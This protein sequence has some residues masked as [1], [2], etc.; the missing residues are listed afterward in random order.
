MNIY[1]AIDLKN[2]QV[3]RLRKG[4]H[5]EQTVYSDSP[6]KVAAGLIEDGARWLHVV[7]LDAA[8]NGEPA[9]M[10]SLMNILAVAKSSGAK[11]QNGGGIRSK[12]RIKTLLD[13]GIER[14][15]IGSA[16]LKDRKWFESILEEQT[17]PNHR[18]ALGLDTREGR[19]ATRGWTEQLDVLATEI[20]GGFRDSGL[21]AIIYTDISRDGMLSGINAEET[22]S[23]IDSTDI[24]VI[25]SGGVS[26]IDDIHKASECGCEGV[27]VGKAI[28]EGTIRLADAMHIFGGTEGN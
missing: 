25:A 20:A 2:G 10:G 24:P 23:V 26:S 8:L 5:D 17:I 14:L 22:K 3:V 9:N 4:N 18:L 6:A 19:V 11:I 28:Y 27:I 13:E 21:G 7:D 15:V 1:P 12:D 16:A